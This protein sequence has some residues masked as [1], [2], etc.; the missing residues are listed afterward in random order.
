MNFG[1]LTANQGTQLIEQVVFQALDFFLGTKN[2]VFVILQLRH[3]KAFS[4]YQGLLTHKV[5]GHAVSLPLGHFN[6]I[7]KD[8]IEAH[9]HGLDAGFFLDFLLKVLHPGLVIRRNELQ[10]IKLG[11]ITRA[12]HAAFSYREGRLIHDGLLQTRSQLLML[13]NFAVKQL[14]S[15]ALAAS[16]HILQ[17][18]QHA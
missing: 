8:L 17:S 10:L 6:V 7:A 13:A 14:Q 2:L 9:L 18:R 3:N 11:V 16:Q 1:N 4:V 5:I 15:F 12:N